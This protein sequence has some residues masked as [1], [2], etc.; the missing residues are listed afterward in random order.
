LG[1]FIREVLTTGKECYELIETEYH[2][3]GMIHYQSNGHCYTVGGT[4]M[5]WLNPFSQTVTVQPQ[6]FTGEL[7]RGARVFVKKIEL[8][9][10]RIEFQL[11]SDPNS[12]S[13]TTRAKLKLFVEG[14]TRQLT[15][16]KAIAA[17]SEV[18]YVEKYEKLR[19]LTNEF[20]KLSATIPSLQA[21]YSDTNL[22]ANQRTQAGHRLRETL[23]KIV[24]NRSSPLQPNNDPAAIQ[25]YRSQVAALD[26]ALPKLDAAAK[27][28]R[29]SSIKAK[30][31]ADETQCAE[32][33][34]QLSG[35]KLVRSTEL[36][37]KFT[38]MRQYRD[39][40]TERENLASQLATEG[41]PVQ[42]LRAK[43]A[44]ESRNL[45]AVAD[46]LET[47]R[48]RIQLDQLNASFEQMKKR[49]IAL[50]DH[51]TRAFGSPQE[52]S[53]LQALIGHMQSMLQNR[54]QAKALGSSAAAKEASL[55]E[56][57]IQ[58]YRRR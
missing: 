4:R 37:D 46:L 54:E 36:E 21:Q 38:K 42:D 40:L 47:D 49:K 6:Q 8:K 12:H 16:E 1:T 25:T 3:D 20:N 7:G 30:T 33:K 2:P 43:L 55:I 19:E 56:A 41:E 17:T 39:L 35:S 48:K 10:D 18:L 31:A 5:D 53:S 51:Y 13:V 24:A 45:D 32:L 50:V 9:D 28:E 11:W 22:S 15:L 34:A 14:G 26:D 52:R 44:A 27:S 23:Q 57:E 58:K 29:I